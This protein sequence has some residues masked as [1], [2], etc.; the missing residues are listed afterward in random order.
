MFTQTFPITLDPIAIRIREVTCPPGPPRSDLYPWPARDDIV[1][2]KS[3]KSVF[4]DGASL[5][6]V[7][8]SLPPIR[9]RVSA[10][11]Q[12]TARCAWRGRVMMVCGGGR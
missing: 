6:A 7:V 9:I 11:V 1:F 3:G 8:L 10:G 4:V 5:R 12:L 2:R